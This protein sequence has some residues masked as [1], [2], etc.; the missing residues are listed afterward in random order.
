M[1]IGDMSRK[2]RAVPLGVPLAVLSAGTGLSL[3]AG[4]RQLHSLCGIGCLG[5][6]ILHT[7]QHGSKLKKDVQKG[8][9]KVGIMD[10]VNIP[11][12]KIDMFVRTVEV[13]AY[14]PGR[15]LRRCMGRGMCLPFMPKAGAVLAIF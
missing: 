9:K 15:V 13:A 12:S 11:R 3:L 6:S 5:L 14:I 1:I 10:F 4:S 8:M 7:W 2:L